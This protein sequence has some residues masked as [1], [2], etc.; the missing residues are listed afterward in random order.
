MTGAK[1]SLVDPVSAGEACPSKPL[2]TEAVICS[3]LSP[4]C[5]NEVASAPAAAGVTVLVPIWKVTLFDFGFGLGLAVALCCCC[6][7]GALLLDRGG[8][9]LPA[10]AA[11]V[12]VAAV[13]VVFLL[14]SPLTKVGVKLALR[15]VV[16]L[17]TD[18]AWEATNFGA[19]P[20]KKEDGAVN[21]RAAG[22]EEEASGL[23]GAA[24]LVV[25]LGF[26][27]TVPPALVAVGLKNSCLATL[28]RRGACAGSVVEA[29][30]GEE[31]RIGM[32]S[33][34]SSVVI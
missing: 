28:S 8:L 2:G 21:G 17:G 4:R 26:F 32:S 13:A 22:A 30:R 9:E 27:V 15:K 24:E 3:I 5:E 18:E 16:K 12:A 34:E 23:A 6:W 1:L 20:R 31:A 33:C 11:A 14:A 29:V 19:A 7:E 25:D 10:P